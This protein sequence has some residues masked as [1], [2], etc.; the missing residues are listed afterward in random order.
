MN[1]HRLQYVQLSHLLA[2]ISQS[3]LYASYVKLHDIEILL[4][5][6][7]PKFYVGLYD[8]HIKEVKGVFKYV[9]YYKR[10]LMFDS[11]ECKNLFPKFY[12][13]QANKDHMILTGELI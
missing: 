4:C 11:M 3:R 13:N 5:N 6:I 12:G 1:I 2:F 10:N 7:S 8:R 9:Y